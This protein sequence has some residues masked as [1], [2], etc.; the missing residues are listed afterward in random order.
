MEVAWS[1]RQKLPDICLSLRSH[2]CFIYSFAL[3]ITHNCHPYSE[4]P[5]FISPLLM[6]YTRFIV[7]IL[8]FEE[9][10]ELEQFINEVE[11]EFPKVWC[12]TSDSRTIFHL[13]EKIYLLLC[14]IL[15][16]LNY[17][18]FCYDILKQTCRCH[19]KVE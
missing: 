16:L 11:L 1:G 14:S 13:L 8:K 3:S 2:K 15:L 10:E 9:R 6:V 7:D 18:D 17:L 5:I 19:N 4:C 12:L